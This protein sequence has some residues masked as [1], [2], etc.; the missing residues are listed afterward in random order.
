MYVYMFDRLIDALI[1]VWAWYAENKGPLTPEP[2]LPYR[3]IKDNGFSTLNMMLLPYWLRLYV[4]S[5][6][7]RTLLPPR[8]KVYKTEAPCQALF[9]R[10]ATFFDVTPVIDLQPPK[11]DA[12]RTAAWHPRITQL[13]LLLLHG[14]SA[15]GGQT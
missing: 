10:L 1:I 13:L 12:T 9:H 14:S 15:T 5:Y 4:T 7:A 3:P 6:D 2:T 8:P 11:C